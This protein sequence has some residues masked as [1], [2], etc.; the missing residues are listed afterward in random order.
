M[1][2]VIDL[3]NDLNL[4]EIIKCIFHMPN[5]NSIYNK[6]VGRPII[7]KGNIYFQFEQFTEKQVFHKNVS[8]DK[9]IESIIEYLSG[10][11]KKLTIHT[12]DF[13][14]DILV[15]NDN[16]KITKTKKKK[17][18]TKQELSHNKTKQYLIPENTI[19]E[20]LI[21]LG[22][23]TK[24]GKIVNS[25]YD[26]YKQINRF[27]ELIYD[28]IKNLNNKKINIIDFGCGKSYLTFVLYYFLKEICK[29]DISIVGL[30][31]KQD[32]IDNCNQIAKKY[33]YENLHFLSGDIKDYLPDMD[34]DIVICLHACDTATDYA[35]FNACKW[36]A[37]AIL[38][39]P[40]CQKEVNKQ[41]STKTYSI[42][43]NYGVVKE[44]FSA[45][46]TDI[47]R[48]NMLELNDYDTQILEFVD[49]A[50]SPK[51]LLI[52]AM[53]KNVSTNAKIKAK[54]EIDAILKEYNIF[55]TICR[56]LE[57]KPE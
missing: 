46:L 21:D 38:S 10:N 28:V 25:K 24:E 35:L 44:R 11:F 17:V 55:P 50:H 33:K 23:F 4:N 42:F 36:N 13:D 18:N 34:I 54:N 22:I 30:D 6:I 39:V 27:L 2:K 53:R 51:N 47:L 41:I 43:T 15:I 52:R 19:V 3:L 32:V 14:Y 40:C 20:P 16:I 48:A 37:K 29:Y 31:L 5:K 1:K 45:M 7:L 9:L 57:F 8:L 49:F 12:I 26:K 56:L